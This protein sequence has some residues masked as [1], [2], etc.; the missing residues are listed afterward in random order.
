MWGRTVIRKETTLFHN[1]CDI[2]IGREYL[3][4]LLLQLGRMRLNY[5]IWM[6]LI[7]Q[8]SCSV[9]DIYLGSVYVN[10]E[11]IRNE[12]GCPAGNK[13]IKGLL[14]RLLLN[15]HKAP[16]DMYVVRKVRIKPKIT[17]DGVDGVLPRLKGH[18]P[19]PRELGQ[20][21]S[22]KADVGTYIIRVAPRG[23]EASQG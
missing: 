8:A 6:V 1:L 7:K 9:Q 19:G 14:T 4:T 22:L 18:H 5:K 16:H 17:L 21:Q 15:P 20:R 3:D 23:G 11:C 10:E 2:A 13:S 12:R